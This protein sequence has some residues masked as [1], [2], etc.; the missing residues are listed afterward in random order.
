MFDRSSCFE[1][2]PNARKS[3]K[4]ATVMQIWNAKDLGDDGH[5]KSIAYP[6]RYLVLGD[7]ESIKDFSEGVES[8]PN[9]VYQHI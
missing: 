1:T 5:F 3:L 6:R 2:D 8:F 4:R 9:G 7:D